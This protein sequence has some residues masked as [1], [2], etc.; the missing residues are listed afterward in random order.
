[1]SIELPKGLISAENNLKRKLFDKRKALILFENDFNQT[2]SIYRQFKINSN[3]K[4]S[5]GMQTPTDLDKRMQ[6]I[7]WWIRQYSPRKNDLEGSFSEELIQIKLKNFNNQL[8]EVHCDQTFCHMDAN[9]LNPTDA[10]FLITENKNQIKDIFYFC[11]DEFLKR[12]GKG[13]ETFFNG[14]ETSKLTDFIYED[15]TTGKHS[16]NSQKVGQEA[17]SIFFPA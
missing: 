2:V 17:D 7:G 13:D 14:G 5:F 15:F 3:R 8:Y 1:M 6:N 11:A 9:G 4:N 16:Q 10:Y 12:I